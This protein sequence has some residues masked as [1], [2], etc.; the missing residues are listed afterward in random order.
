[1]DKMKTYTGKVFSPLEPTMQDIDIHDISHALSFMTR[2]NGHVRTF[3]SVAQHSI[4]CCIE[5]KERGYSTRVQLALLL[6]DASEAYI[7]DIIRPVKKYMESYYKIEE[8]LQNV[9]YN[10]YLSYELSDEEKEQIKSV[11]D[12]MLAW[13]LVTLM[14]HDV[15]DNLPL[16]MSK[17]S[18]DFNS[19]L[20]IEEEYLGIFKELI[21]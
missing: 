11:D 21:K 13:E 16:I 3:F 12:A 20:D 18:F 7:A 2:A 6:H 19:F 1:M 5:A 9:I 14:N 4:N 8:V 15:C 10:K 17:P